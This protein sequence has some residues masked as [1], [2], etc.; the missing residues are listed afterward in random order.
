MIIKKLTE[1]QGASRHGTC[2][3]CGE[4]EGDTHRLYK[5]IFFTQT[6]H[7]CPDC[8]RKLRMQMNN[9]TLEG[10]KGFNRKEQSE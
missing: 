10:Y 2:A 8:F 3:E 7:L 9:I 1:C 5:L 4:C 6:I